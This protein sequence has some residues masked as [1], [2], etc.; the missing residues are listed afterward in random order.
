MTDFWFGLLLFFIFVALVFIAIFLLY[1]AEGI[2]KMAET[3][4]KNR[5]A[6]VETW[7]DD[8]GDIGYEVHYEDEDC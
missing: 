3:A 6:R 5:V 7:K 8:C 4:R 2:R 1:I